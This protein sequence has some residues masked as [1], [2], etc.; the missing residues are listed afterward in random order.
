MPG[1]RPIIHAAELAE[2]ILSEVT[3]PRPDWVSLR[4]LAI[5]LAGL[6]D[7]QAQEEP[8]HQSQAGGPGA[9]GE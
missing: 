4:S 7:G 1:N 3:R 6:A 2:E 8:T 9:P 5:S